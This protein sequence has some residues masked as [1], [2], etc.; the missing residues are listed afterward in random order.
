MKLFRSKLFALIIVAFIPLASIFSQDKLPLLTQDDY[1]KWERL[2]QTIIS[3]DGN[4]VAY[5]V[6]KI[7]GNDTLYIKSMQT[8]SLYKSAFSSGVQFSK[9]G[10]WIAYRVGYSKKKMDQMRES[11]KPIVYKMELMNL[12]TGEKE[13]I[14]D[15]SRFS[16]SEKSDFIAIHKNKPAGS[17][18]KGDNV[19]LRNLKTGTDFL[20][21]NLTSYSFNKKG[22]YLAY[23]TESEGNTGNGVS[24]FDLKEYQIKVL[25]SDTVDFSQLIWEKEGNALAFMKSYKNDDFEEDNNIIYTYRNIYKKV[26]KQVYDPANDK[27]FPEDFYINKSYRLSWA[28]DLSSVFFGVKE[29]TKKEKKEKKEEGEKKDK[30]G[31]EKKGEGDDKKD[32]KKTEKKKPEAKKDEKLPGVDV[33]H[34]DDDRIQPLQKKRYNS[35]KNF[36]YIAGWKIEENNFIQIADE[37]IKNARLTGDQKFAYA[38]DQTPYEPAFKMSY[39]DYYLIDLSTGKRE[40]IFDNFAGSFSSSPDGKYLIYFKDKN[41]WTFDINNRKH[42]NLTANTDIDFWNT[43]DDH[44]QELRPA[45]G[46]G[47]WTNDDKEV[48]LYD[49]YDVYSFKPDGSEFKRLTQGKEL[50]TIFRIQRLDY[51]NDYI[52]VKEPIY[53]RAS[54]D[55]SKKSGLYKMKF[56]SDAEELIFVDKR[57]RVQKAKE[58]DKFIYTAQTYI[59]SPNVFYVGSDFKNPKKLSDTN[60]QQ[61]EFAWGKTELINY[62]NADGVELQGSLHYPANYESGKKFPMVVYIYEL[63]SGAIHSYITP[64]DKSSYNVTNYVQQGFFVFQPDIIYKDDLP[65]VSSVDCV[66]PAVKKVIS[67]GMIDEKRIGLMGHSW[68]AYQT[69]FIIT[70]TDIFSAAVAGAPLTDMISM[71][72]EIYW[73]SGSPNAKIFETSQGRFTKPYFEELDIY[74]RNSPMFNAS[75]INTPLL[76]TFGD[77]D[78]AVDWHQGIEMYTT[79]RRMKKNMIMLVYA[80]ENHGLRKDE[81]RLDY[82]KKVNEFFN[83]YLLDKEP[84]KWISEGVSYVDKMKKEEKKKK[85]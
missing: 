64:S 82:T 4:W 80:D 57:I 8:D 23:I 30:E 61:K 22:D 69:A 55:K 60:P 65:G 37:K 31:E 15:A 25:E 21:G 38:Y 59:E 84:A 83:H 2:G 10:N 45:F 47:G 36:S 72:T 18:T 68:G 26:N 78:G 11:K 79:M 66:V 74:M 70:A 33:W 41:W 19:V 48:L 56:G 71:Y 39:A 73:N 51:E 42:T 29:W 32:D 43:R 50:E 1:L 34:W 13:L 24:L 67:T 12:V 85:K 58:V 63:R 81:N 14:K 35:D 17:K 27:S 6:A 76:V 7:E 3:T 62:V 53:L 16:F 52:D 46:S 54:G 9:D 5:S 77:K 40:K 20:L 28:E 49:E 75:K 44:P